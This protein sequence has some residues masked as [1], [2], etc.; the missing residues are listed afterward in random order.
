MAKKNAIQNFKLPEEVKK[1]FND[2]C[3]EN[4]TSASHELRMFV[5]KK[6]EEFRQKSN[7]KENSKPLQ[8]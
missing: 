8:S 2:L 7:S 4:F 6:N 1:E 3:E 5:H